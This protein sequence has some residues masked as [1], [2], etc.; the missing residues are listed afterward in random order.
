MSLNE[1]TENEP[2]LHNLMKHDI[3]HSFAVF[4]HKQSTSIDSSP[5]KPEFKRRVFVHGS[6]KVLINS[7]TQQKSLNYGVEHGNYVPVSEK[8]F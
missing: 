5:Q 1:N 3:F 8:F 7:E 4:L 6:L 2:Q